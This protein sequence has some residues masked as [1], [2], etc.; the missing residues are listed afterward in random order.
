MN[1]FL[2]GMV[3]SEDVLYFIIVIAMFLSSCFLKIQLG[4]ARYSGLSKM[5]RYGGVF[6]VAMLA[7][8]VT[9]R[10][11]LKVYYDGTYTKANTIS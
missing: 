1:T 11:V 2:Q 8:Y 3:C 6:A 4:R 9:S 10:P 5:M 7:G